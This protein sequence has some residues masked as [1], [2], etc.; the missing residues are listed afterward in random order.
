MTSPASPSW[1]GVLG[2]LAAGLDLDSDSAAWAV[3]QVM[4]G[5]AAPA[6]VGAFLL[7][8]QAKGPT[9]REIAAAAAVMRDAALPINVP[10][11]L[12][13]VVG[14]G[15]DGS[16]SVNFSTMAAIVAV[17][18]GATVVK[19]GN[20]AASSKAGTADV[21]EELGVAIDL[22]P[23][24]IAS[25]ARE[26]GI[27]F[28]FAQVLHPAMKHAAQIRREL[29]VP[30]IFNTLGP[31]TNP[32]R[33][34]AGLIGCA[35]ER[36]APL[37]AQVFADR[38]DRVFVVRGE[39]GWDEISPYGVTQVWDTTRGGVIEERVYAADLGMG[40]IA[41]GALVGGDPVT[42]AEVCR[43]AFGMP[44]EHPD[45][46]LPSDIDA[47]R[48][49]VSANAAAALA[50]NAAAHGADTSA[51][52]LDRIKAHLGDTRAAIESGAAGGILRRWID[53]SRALARG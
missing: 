1:P 28:A 38:G 24:A 40:G 26:A 49:V 8:V 36:S 9:A 13:D 34:T 19:H 47:V 3:A 31:L 2:R 7:G 46:A 45:L 53:T 20:R 10:G 41:E 23:D 21:L 16:G 44:R 37:M 17:A 14:T 29:G 4:S 12:L 42:N 6:Q 15:G 30:T 48:A 39:T 18:C 43:A 51:P 35:S 52:L 27:A 32:A 33:P 5:E 11:V 50:A 25:C 22:G